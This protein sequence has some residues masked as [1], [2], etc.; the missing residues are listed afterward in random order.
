MTPSTPDSENL[1]RKQRRDQAREHRKAN[2]EAAAAESA[3]RRRLIQLGGVAGVVVVAIIAI[4]VATSKSKNPT[5]ESHTPTNTT[6][7]NA[8]VST[9]EGELNGIP[10]SGN[11]L[12]K[13]N[14]PVT[15]QYFGDLECP[16]CRQFTLTALPGIVQNEVRTGKLKIEYKSMETATRNPP[17][18][19]KQQSAAYAAGRQNKAWYFIELFYNE[20][21]KEDSGYV[22][23]S[24]LEGLASQ[25]PGL[26]LSQWHTDRKD[27]KLEAQ[28]LADEKE[29]SE[30]GFTGTPSFMLGKTGQK[31]KP[32]SSTS[33]ESSA[34]FEPTINQ[35]AS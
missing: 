25:V 19:L 35:L 28:V 33:L 15:M 34:A 3:R 17:V 4:V 9:V 20:Q 11:V 5:T 29:A 10:Q 26:S 27:E 32:F 16:F 14:A 21:G 1:T 30:I 13:P 2:E 31:L 6:A 18:F 7:Q 22:T 12:G 24:Y 8:A 23:E